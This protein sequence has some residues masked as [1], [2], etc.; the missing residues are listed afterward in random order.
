M[1]AKTLDQLAGLTALAVLLI[2]G[3]LAYDIHATK[4]HSKC[5]DDEAAIAEALAS[6]QL[7]DPSV[8]LDTW[9]FKSG[10]G[11][12]NRLGLV[13]VTLGLVV[14]VATAATWWRSRRP[15][16]SHPGQE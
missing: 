7:P 8:L 10:C 15:S 5:L 14:L 4:A 16:A 11:D 9:V 13:A 3:G 2:G 12:A 6:Q 1:R